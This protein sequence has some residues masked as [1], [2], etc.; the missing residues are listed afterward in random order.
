MDRLFEELIDGFEFRIAVLNGEIE[1]Y[2]QDENSNQP[3]F[4]EHA[5]NIACKNARI[6]E[7]DLAISKL[8]KLWNEDQQYNRVELSK[9]GSKP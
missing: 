5:I 2:R 9:D 6:S 3:I 7:L 4:A 8:K 1:M